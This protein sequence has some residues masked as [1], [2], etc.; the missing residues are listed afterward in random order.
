NPKNILSVLLLAAVTALPSH[1]DVK[2]L[3]ERYNDARTGANLFEHEL[4]SRNVNVSSFGKLFSHA[5]SGAVQAQI[6]Y[7]PHLLIPGKGLHN[8]IFVPTMNDVL[9]AFD[10]DDNQG[11]NANPLWVRDFTDPAHGITAVPITDIVVTNGPGNIVGNVGIES[12]PVIDRRS[13]T[14]Y[15]L[16]RTKENGAY[17]QRLHAVALE[18]GADLPGGVVTIQGKV[19][20]LTFDPLI[21]NQRSALALARGQVFIAW[22]SNEDANPYHGWVMSYD[23]TTLAQTGVFCTSP[24]GKEGGIWM[25]GW[26]P[27][28]DPEG[29]VYYISG[30]GDWNGVDNFGQ[31]FLKFCSH[32]LQLLDWFTPADW[33]AM[34]AHDFDVGASGGILIPGTHLLVAGGKSGIFYLLDTRHLGHLTAGDTGAVQE[35]TINSL[36]P[37][38]GSIKEGPVYWNRHGQKGPWLYVWAD[39]DYLRAFRFN[40]Q[41]FDPTPVSQSTFTAPTGYTTGGSLALSADGQRPGSG[42]LWASIPFNG[43][44]NHGTT[45]GVLRAFDADDLTKE[46]WNSEQN[47]A[48]D[49]LGDWPKF[50]PPTVANGKVYEPSFS[51]QI[52]VYGLLRPSAHDGGD[53]NDRH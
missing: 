24:T 35:L 53:G 8:V 45:P 10:A 36:V 31:T 34:N 26:A 11:S 17:F 41:T 25:A 42:I 21:Q 30:N 46:L 44:G 18:T 40:G 12:T 28:V 29:N 38:H 32:G 6:L 23:A 39:N 48:R 15:V 19:G 37:P 47:S 16:V 13:S 4:N 2:V 52:S 51:G 7:V 50:S 9:Y 43:D 22:A 5:V 33:A 27:A 20:A 3:T 49:S 1:A 14:M